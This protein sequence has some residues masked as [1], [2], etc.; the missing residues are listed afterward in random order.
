MDAFVSILISRREPAFEPIVFGWKENRNSRG[1][2]ARGVAI[3]EE[4]G[5]RTLAVT[6]IG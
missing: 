4:V 1:W 6:R 3:A 5:P 2:V